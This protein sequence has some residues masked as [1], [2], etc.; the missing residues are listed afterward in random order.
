MYVYKITNR[1]NNKV[2]IGITNNYETRW[3]LHKQTSVNERHAEYDKV[4]YRAFRKYGLDNFEFKILLDGLS[5]DEAKAK[6]I[7]Y[8]AELNCLSSQ[9]GYNV[10]AGGDYS[11]GQL[12]GEDSPLAKY[13]E[14]QV[15]DIIARRDNGELRTTLFEEYGHI[16]SAGFDDIWLG[17]SWKYLQPKT[18]DKR[19]G[20]RYLTDS[21]VLEIRGSN[22]S[23]RALAKQYGV[24]PSTI[25]NIINFKTY[26]N[27]T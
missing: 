10:T 18:I 26:K 3:R 21:E 9:N 16:G 7:E 24:P 5:L 27:V 6:E 25:S 8:I 14:E 11:A 19:H 17:R 13:T 4:L 1:I 2:Y 15:K 20:N 12:K 23:G 22:L